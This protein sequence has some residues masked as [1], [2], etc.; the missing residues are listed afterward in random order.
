MF[1]GWLIKVHMRDWSILIGGLGPVQQA[2]GHILFSAKI[3][4]E[5]EPKQ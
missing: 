1:Y 3:I 5:L 2:I 4:I